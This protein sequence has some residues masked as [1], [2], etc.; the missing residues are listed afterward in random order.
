MLQ[1]TSGVSG[2]R[3]NADQNGNWYLNNKSYPVYDSLGVN[4]N[5]IYG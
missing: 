3:L 5:D 2:G 4:M 1:D